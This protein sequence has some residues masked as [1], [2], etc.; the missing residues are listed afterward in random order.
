VAIRAA[1]IGV[2][3]AIIKHDLEKG[4]PIAQSVR[5]NRSIPTGRF[6]KQFA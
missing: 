5:D 1:T 3:F 6:L 4:K 2:D